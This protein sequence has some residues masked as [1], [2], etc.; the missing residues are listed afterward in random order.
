MQ[1]K[2]IQTARVVL[3]GTICGDIIGSV[4]E[5]HKT[6]RLDFPLFGGRNR[7]TDD[8]VCTV[9]VAD[10][11]VKGLPFQDSILYWCR[12]YPH[13]GYGKRFKSW[14]HSDNPEPYCSYGNGSAMRVSPI[15]SFADTMDECLDLARQS[16][17]ITHNQPE[18]VKGAQAVA[19]AIFMALRGG[20]KSEIRDF[21]ESQFGYDLR[22]RY[23]DIQP[24]YRFHVSCQKS[25]PESIIAFLESSDYESAVRM[26][27]AYGGDADTMAAIAGGIAAAFY[28]EI[29]QIIL[30]HCFHLLPNDIIMAIKD[31]NQ[32]IGLS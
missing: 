7:F 11:I 3:Y 30:N 28:G 31:F 21:I 4:Y 13:S 25:V 1:S 15:G 19:V 22:R 23:A 20:S 27:V 29:P 2:E 18:G 14:F 9:A 6:K 32:V 10:A 16:A 17:E 8:T 26:A 24:T 12:K 5:G